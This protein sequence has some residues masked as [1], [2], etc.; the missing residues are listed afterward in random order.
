MATVKNQVSSFDT[1]QT[2]CKT[3]VFLWIKSHHNYFFKTFNF[4]SVLADSRYQYFQVI[5]LAC[6]SLKLKWNIVE[7]YVILPSIDLYKSW[8]QNLDN[9]KLLTIHFIEIQNYALTHITTISKI[10]VFILLYF[11]HFSNSNTYKWFNTFNVPLLLFGINLIGILSTK[12][13]E[14]NKLTMP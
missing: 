10:P 6:F 1:S 3:S 12:A 5:Q 11:Y 13:R 9:K 14:K 7:S 8:L 2:S 4:K